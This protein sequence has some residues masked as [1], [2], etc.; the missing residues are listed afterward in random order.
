SPPRAEGSWPGFGFVNPTTGVKCL[1]SPPQ[2]QELGTPRSVL[3]GPVLPTPELS[4]QTRGRGAFRPAVSRPVPRSWVA[5]GYFRHGN[6]AFD[7][8]QELGE[9]KA[10]GEERDTLHDER[11]D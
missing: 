6:L 10:A 9:K 5:K 2:N 1:L 8:A 3:F 11:V 7:V 4:P